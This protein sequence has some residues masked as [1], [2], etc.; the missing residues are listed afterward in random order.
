MMS[1]VM[2]LNGAVLRARECASFFSTIQQFEVALSIP[3][4]EE[5]RQGNEG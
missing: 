1:V 3:R 5:A 2:S 4:R